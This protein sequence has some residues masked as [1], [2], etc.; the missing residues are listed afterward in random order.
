[1]HIENTQ[2]EADWDPE[3]GTASLDAA[4]TVLNAAD[5][6]TVRATL[7][8]ADGNTVWQTTGDAEAQTA[9]SS[10]PLQGSPL[11]RRKPDAVRA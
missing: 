10:G 5:A 7:K 1:M 6:A 3:A 11:E 2:I 4:L 9:I 8:D